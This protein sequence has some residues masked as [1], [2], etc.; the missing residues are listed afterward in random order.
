MK[1][2]LEGVGEE[3]EVTGQVR[4]LWV[5]TAEVEGGEDGE[6]KDAARGDFGL[7]VI[8]GQGIGGNLG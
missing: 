6:G 1:R 5:V 7:G 2:P 3:A 8:P 4:G